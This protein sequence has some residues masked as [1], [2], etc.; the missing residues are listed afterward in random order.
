M[1]VYG[2][3]GTRDGMTPQQKWAVRCLL[4]DGTHFHNGCAR[5]SDSE[6]AIIAWL[7]GI[8]ITAHPAS[9]VNWYDRVHIRAQE[10][11]EPM[12]PLVRNKIIVEESTKIIAT[13]KETYEYPRGG[14]PRGSGTWATIREAR[15]RQK[16]LLL[17]WPNGDIHREE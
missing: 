2:F 15:R 5:G 13:P 12:P 3:T 9:N 10:V 6:S 11:R 8:P 16:P 17:V 4:L 14:P 1:T 7:L